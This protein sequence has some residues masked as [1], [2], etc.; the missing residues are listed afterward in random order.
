MPRETVEVY[1][2][3]LKCKHTHYEVQTSLGKSNSAFV[4]ITG[5][6]AIAFAKKYGNTITNV[7]RLRITANFTENGELVAECR[8]PFRPLSSLIGKVASIYDIEVV[9]EGGA[10]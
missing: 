4:E 6:V 5:D 9:G 8:N 1:G 2:R 7:D 3:E 10:R